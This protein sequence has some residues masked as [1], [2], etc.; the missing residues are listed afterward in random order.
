MRSPVHSL[1]HRIGLLLGSVVLLVTTACTSH[2]ADIEEYHLVLYSPTYAS[3][4]TILGADTHASTLIKVQNPWQGAEGV[5]RHLFIARNGEQ[6]PRG[7]TGE[8]VRGDAKRIVCMSSSHVAM[9][10]ALGA[11]TCVAGVSGIDFITNDYVSTHRDHIGDVGYEGNMNYELLL[12]LEPDVVLLFGLTGAS[13]LE[14]KLKELGIPFFYVGEYLEE[15]PL[16][17]SEWMVALGELI[18]CRS[19]AESLFAAIPQRY[20]TWKRLAQQA[21]T[22][23]PKVMINTPYADSWFMAPTTSYVA[24][25]IADAGGDYLYR[26]NHTSVSLPIDLEAAALLTSQADLWMNVGSIATL[27]D[28]RQRFPKFADVPCV[29]RGAVYNCDRRTNQRGGNDYWESGVVQ[30]DVV[31]RDLVKLFHPELAEA[32]PFV[33]YRK[34]E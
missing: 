31:L 10:D 24:R 9:L 5:D 17:K 18:G 34:L 27:N 29:R 30:P 26:D 12:A 13:T 2:R 25:L 32:Y 19:T 21:Q 14:P 28:L 15:N 23:R 11:A 22:P 4:F 7:F 6:P 16:G 3:G 33:Y 20:N 8:V 1:S